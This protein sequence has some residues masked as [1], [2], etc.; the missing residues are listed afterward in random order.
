MVGLVSGLVVAVSAAQASPAGQLVVCAVVVV[1]AVVGAGTAAT[2]AQ[3]A[4]AAGVAA[5]A[6]PVGVAVVSL[7]AVPQ[8]RTQL[9]P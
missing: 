3:A 9:A 6:A 7:A 4:A 5:A 2:V 8:Q 1:G